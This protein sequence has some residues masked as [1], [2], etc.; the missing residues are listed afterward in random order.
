MRPW[1]LNHTLPITNSIQNAENAWSNCCST[2]SVQ[3]ICLSNT[4]FA[5]WKS[6]SH[7]YFRYR[8]FKGIAVKILYEITWCLYTVMAY[9]HHC[10]PLF[11][12][13]LFF[14]PA[15][16]QI[17]EHHFLTIIISNET[18]YEQN[19]HNLCS[20]WLKMIKQMLALFSP[21]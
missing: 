20:V 6:T 2:E 17:Y 15:L 5:V 7:Y 12:F 14:K 4:I 19:W 11:L 21:K 1:W 13:V 16:F 18:L 8:G 9:S 10:L 3:Y